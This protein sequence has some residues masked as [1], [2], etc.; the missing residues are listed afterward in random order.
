ML[1]LVPTYRGSRNAMDGSARKKSKPLFVFAVAKTVNRHRPVAGG[2]HNREG[3]KTDAKK[4][5]H[6]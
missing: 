3:A 5:R 1:Y 6:R 2:A 4:Y